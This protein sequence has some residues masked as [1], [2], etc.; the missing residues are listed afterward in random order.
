MQEPLAKYA[1]LSVCLSVP[2]AEV[3]LNFL[4][5]TEKCFAKPFPCALGYYLPHAVSMA[6]VVVLCVYTCAKRLRFDRSIMVRPGIVA[7]YDPP[8]KCRQPNHDA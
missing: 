7:L 4:N 3:Y 1:M 2:R 6:V 8:V 5:V